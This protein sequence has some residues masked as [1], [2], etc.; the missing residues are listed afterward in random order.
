MILRRLLSR[1][2]AR[3][4]YVMAALL[5]A[6]AGLAA[7][8]TAAR[9]A[10]G[11]VRPA[12]QPAPQP[13]S[14]RWT[15]TWTAAQTPAA[16]TGISASGFHDQTI[17]MIVHTTAGGSALRI[18]LSNQYGKAP[19][20]VGDVSAGVQSSGAAEAQA[21]AH[22]LTFSGN[23]S[24]VIPAG[25]K[26]DSDPVLM[27]V[28]AGQNVVVSV[29]LP[30]ATGP[31][32]WHPVAQQVNYLGAGD[33]TADPAGTGY[34]S[35]T[36]SWFYL[37]GVSVQTAT[38]RGAIAA[39][40]DSITDG[41]GSTT[42]ANHRWPD[43]LA[44]RLSTQPADSRYAVADA[45][46]GGNRVLTDAG[47]CCTTNGNYGTSAE[48]RF[49]GDALKLAG[50]KTVIFFEGINDI[51]N[52]VADQ[53]GDPIT[54]QALIDG[55]RNVI[56]Q[57]HNAGVTIIG[58]TLTP[59]NG[60]YFYSPQGE[61]IR[62]QV[63]QWIRTS[64]AFDS[65]VDFDKAIRDP[66]HP[67]HLLPGYDSGDHIHPNDAGY[68]A[69]ANA[70]FGAMGIIPQLSVDEISPPVYMARPGG[71]TQFSANVTNPGPFPVEN[72][73]MTPAAPAGWAITPLAAGPRTLPPGATGTWRWQ[74]ST[75]AAAGPGRYHGTLTLRYASE[76]QPG[77]ATRDVPMLL[78]VI[79]HDGMSASA[80][81][82]QENTNDAYYAVDDGPS[83]LWHS[84]YS[85]YQPLPHEITLNLG[86]GYAV[87]GLNY[88]PRQDGNH[89]GDI[90]SY[91]VSV[92]TDGT[93][94][95]QVTSGN[96]ADDATQKTASFAAQTA[97][98]VRL[99]ALAGH[100]N[101]ASAAE[102]DILGTPPG[103]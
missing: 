90:T 7:P 41:V 54:T 80:D 16:A 99:T 33:Q 74:V 56:R 17:R 94:F 78:G 23:R 66:V 49:A 69:M 38:V 68:Q 67:D 42:N 25:A 76:G 34:A 52:G 12:S 83:T 39:F 82:A 53:A 13:A 87:S 5:A 22:P 37:D 46:I 20:S 57:A 88:L 79:P 60:F 40:G 19:L 26:A 15:Q 8:S 29:Y 62:E 85:P 96:W 89:N 9:A 4:V 65:V 71:T 32:T 47:T 100:S 11:T 48:S 102:I 77:L 63:N 58:G 31:A 18:Q 86:A 81:S 45:G 70:Q 1:T 30:D 72:L 98:Y 24:F 92:S 64:G 61:Q 36:S 59:Y 10:A 44:Q 27:T 21:T 35:T 14:P 51:G 6:T 73:A 2:L 101:L 91:A 75:P 3:P 43:Y 28:P 97:R 93:N 50:V 55:Y 103:S 95:T 84:Q